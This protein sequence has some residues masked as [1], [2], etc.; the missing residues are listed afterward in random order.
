MAWESCNVSQVFGQEFEHDAIT[1]LKN[2]SSP[3]L[4]ND[5]QPSKDTYQ[6]DAGP[7]LYD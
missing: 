4:T 3:K 6:T 7:R 5:R 1:P 2:Q